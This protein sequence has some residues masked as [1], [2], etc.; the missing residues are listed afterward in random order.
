M[1]RIIFSA[2]IV[3]CA[4]LFLAV[5]PA[6]RAQTEAATGVI[7]GTLRD[8]SGA[9]LPK[10]TIQVHHT[11]TGLVREMTSNDNGYYR[12]SLL[13]LGEYVIEA[14]HDG[15]A[16]VKRTGIRLGIG[17]ELVVDFSMQLASVGQS[18]VVNAEAPVVET[19]RYDRTQVL[20]NQSIDNLPT[21]GRDF[22]NFVLLT[23][24]ANL[25]PSSNVF[26]SAAIVREGTSRT[27]T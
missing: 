9:I 1:R 15:F 17:Q 21:N 19:T 8:P 3:A 16:T 7:A 2:R 23:P 26:L 27:L 14:S 5:L 20:D 10:S 13:P 6:L 4:S 12:F 25:I 11:Q 18:V 24:S 22:T